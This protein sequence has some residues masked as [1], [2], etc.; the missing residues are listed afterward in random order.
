MRTR[1]DWRDELESGKMAG[2]LV[3]RTDEGRVGF[4][5]AYSGNLT[6]SNDHEYFVPPI[7]DILSPSGY[8]LA[9][10][11]N[12]S[13]INK[14]ITALENSAELQTA[15]ADVELVRRRG[16]EEIAMFKMKMAADKLRRDEC[17]RRGEAE[18]P[19]IAESQ[20]QKAELR[21]LR[22]RIDAA[23]EEAR[24][25]EM[26]LTDRIEAMRRERRERS[27]ALQ[28]RLFDS[29]VVMN[30]IGERRTLTEIFLDERGELPPAGA[31]ECA[32]PKL[33]Q[34]AYLQ[35]YQPIAMGEFWQGRS[36]V[37]EVR[38]HGGFYPACKSKCEPI[39][40]FMLR[41]LTVD[42]NPL[43]ADRSLEKRL[44][45]VYE[46]RWLMVVDKPSGMPSV[47]SPSAGVS[48]VE[49]VRRRYPGADVPH[50]LDQHT[51]GLLVV[52]KTSDVS[53][54]LKMMFERREVSKTYIALLDGDVSVDEGEIDLPLSAD[55]SNRPMQMVDREGGKR[56]VTR[57]RV[58]GRGDGLTRVE[59]RPLT[60]RTHQLRVHCAH[61]DGLNA[62]IHG[63]M[64][65]G[66]AADRLCLH[67]CTLCFAH[68]VTGES[69]S[70]SSSPEF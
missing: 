29:Y 38:R 42:R 61:L 11:R 27:T 30:A 6:H 26:G 58:V 10:E 46:D 1:A 69:V 28:K 4:L 43:E 19:L 70:V 25:R 22:R 49:S 52:A 44:K 24:R 36:P 63:D 7:Y 32:A 68:P 3:V 64:L 66:T 55:Y 47:P 33:L 59:M 12:I 31:G 50:R 23:V 35:G 62:P 51:S 45:T 54:R 57:F 41:G 18:S 2:V 48:V 9:E 40:R 14:R 34:Y 17:R 5:A 13:E 65:Y 60:G 21:R 56:A 8:F 20:F 16:E 53:R 67:A 39:L 37:G 15:R